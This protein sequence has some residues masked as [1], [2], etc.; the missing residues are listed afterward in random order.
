MSKKSKAHRKKVAKRNERLAGDPNAARI[1]AKVSKTGMA[2]PQEA[3]HLAKV[4]ASKGKNV[5]RFFQRK[6]N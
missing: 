5:N 1:K 2:T 4:H 3:L 6:T